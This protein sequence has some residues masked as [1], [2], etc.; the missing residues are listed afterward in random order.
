M[1]KYDAAVLQQFADSL[2]SK[3]RNIVTTYAI[4]GLAI[5]GGIG[6]ALKIA[7]HSG[8]GGS[9][10]ELFALAIPA[11]MGLALGINAGQ[12]KAFMLRLEAQR[13][14]CQLQIEANTRRLQDIPEPERQHAAKE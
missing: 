6:F 12:M 11:I 9:Q 1:V 13:T 7:L 10:I 8:R 2:Y 3:A 4:L 14:L 5:G